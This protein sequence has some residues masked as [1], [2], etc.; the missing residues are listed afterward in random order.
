MATSK[1]LASVIVLVVSAAGAAACSGTSA[2]ALFNETG[3]G[4]ASGTTGGD[5]AAGAE[6]GA[7]TGGGTGDGGGGGG[8]KH[9]AAAIDSG[10]VTGTCP[11]GSGMQELESND[12]STTA[13]L[14]PPNTDMCGTIS[15]TNDVD[16]YKFILPEST[17]NMSITFTGQV[18]VIVNVNG[19]TVVLTPGST[20]PVP[21][22]KN[23]PYVLDVQTND[24]A[25]PHDYLLRLNLS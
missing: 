9:D 24:G 5:A 10:P 17:Q 18:K 25:A 12:S 7:G 6:T 4:S 2:S 16:F 15:T 11:N 21:V 14:L 1:A 13:N 19:Q 3:D 23:K 22:E 20:Q 8:G